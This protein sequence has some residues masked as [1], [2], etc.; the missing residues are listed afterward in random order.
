MRFLLDQDVYALTARFLRELGHDLVTAAELGLSRAAD[1]VLLA[2][3]GQ[4]SRIFVTRDKDF[5]GLVFVERLG[6]GVVYLRITP[7]TVQTTH[8][9]L[10]LVLQT[11]TESGQRRV[12]GASIPALQ[13]S[14]HARTQTGLTHGGPQPSSM[15]FQ[16]EE[17]SELFIRFFQQ[18][19]R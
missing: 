5:G 7:S 19:W 17:Q 11:H 9:Q 2:R 13:N 6:K 8:E 12:G 14:R 1:T 16:C 10:K 4:E 3:A 18:R 15:A